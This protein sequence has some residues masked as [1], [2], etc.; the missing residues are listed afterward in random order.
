MSEPIRTETLTIFGGKKTVNIRSSDLVTD[1]GSHAPAFAAAPISQAV[2]VYPH[3]GASAAKAAL[4]TE[5][6]ALIKMI[7][8]R[9]R[10]A[11]KC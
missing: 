6:G 8:S 4:V 5:V 10:C 7:T 3:R 2:V 9:R 1:G 11:F